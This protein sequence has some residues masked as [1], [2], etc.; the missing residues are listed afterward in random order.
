MFF[1]WASAA[2]CA[3]ASVPERA[4]PNSGLSLVNGSFETGGSQPEG[5]HLYPGASWVTATAYRGTRSLSGVS[6]REELIC[7][8][9]MVQLKAGADYRLSGRI[10]CTSG[11]ARLGVDLLD[12]HGHLISQHVASPL[13]A[14]LGW[15][16]V[17]AEINAGIEPQLISRKPEDGHVNTNTFRARVW[18]RLKGRAQID[19][20][21]LAP[22]AASFMG[23]KGLEADERG[24]IGFWG[25]EKDDTL[26]PGRR[27]GEFRPDPTNQREGKS[28]ALL[29]PSADWVAI[30]SINYGLAPW[31]ERYE[32]STWARCE[33]AATAQ[34]LA[35]W[36]DDQQKVVRVDA[37]TPVHGES[38][39]PLSLS[40]TAPANA[41]SVRLV[42]PTS[43]PR[44]VPPRSSSSRRQAG[45]SG[46]RPFAAPGVFTKVPMM[47]GVGIFGVWIFPRATKPASSALALNWAKRRAIQSRS[48]LDRGRC[49]SKPRKALSIFSSSNV[50]ALKC[51]DGTKRVILMMRNCRTT[52]TSTLLAA[53]T[54]RAIITN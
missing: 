14:S 1:L 45:R 11:L 22:A 52:P 16:Y 49:S 24:R 18:F 17:G 2:C 8:S 53:G 33:A 43:F 47:T 39:Q 36:T 20:V 5:W 15:C 34:I 31:T 6:K 3:F 21:S 10:N 4:V 42:A 9:D 25:E 46:S 50:A 35:C 44:T 27:A 54:A 13:R 30:S 37:S 23:N 19:D 12:D 51:P 32:L 26:L 29:I 38:W 40:L 28:S 7:E 41:S 48:W